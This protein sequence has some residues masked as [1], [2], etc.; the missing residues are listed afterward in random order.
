MSCL[1]KGDVGNQ[2]KL[3]LD[4]V[5]SE[6][7]LFALTTKICNNN[8]ASDRGLEGG[9]RSW[10]SGLHLHLL[11]EFLQYYVL[12]TIPTRIT[13]L[14]TSFGKTFFAWRFILNVNIFCSDWLYLIRNRFYF[15]YLCFRFCP[16]IFTLKLN[17]RPKIG[18]TNAISIVKWLFFKLLSKKYFLLF[19][20][21]FELNMF[22]N[23]IVNISEKN[24]QAE[25]VENLPPSY[26][27]YRFLHNLHSILLWVKVKILDFV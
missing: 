12:L 16:P 3:W 4:G 1:P 25:L 24:E 21:E 22:H 20:A 9:G 27:P 18:L 15:L 5:W 6:S 2:C 19:F 11:Q 10:S 23:N 8:A 7:T 17:L 26:L 13:V 14:S